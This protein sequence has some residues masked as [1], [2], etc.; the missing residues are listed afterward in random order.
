MA[1]L[2]EPW[3]HEEWETRMRALATELDMKAGDLFMVLRVAVTGSTISPPLYES[4][5]I[6]GKDEVLT[7]TDAALAKLS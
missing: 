4:M 6:L 7:R 3:T 1:S 5:E 2:P